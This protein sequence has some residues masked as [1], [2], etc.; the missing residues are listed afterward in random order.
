MTRKITLANGSTIKV[1]VPLTRLE[2]L[3]ARHW[4]DTSKSAYR[5]GIGG[6]VP[7]AAMYAA[8]SQLWF[9]LGGLCGFLG[10]VAAALSKS[11]V[12][13][14]AVVICISVPFSAIGLIRGLTAGRITRASFSGKDSDDL[15]GNPE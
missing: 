5:K 7:M 13:V 8:S 15:W 1:L 14:M 10:F 12:V 9:R 2:T 11:F 6:Y 4:L 3:A